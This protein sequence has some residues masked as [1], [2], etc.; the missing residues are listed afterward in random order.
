MSYTTVTN[1]YYSSTTVYIPGNSY[2]VNFE[3]RGAR[4][5]D[6]KPYAGVYG[7]RGNGRIGNFT[8]K[9]NFVARSLS[10]TIGGIGANG[11]T[12][13]G[14][15][16]GG[17][18]RSGGTGGSGAYSYSYR[19]DYGS[20]CGPCSQVCCG[21]GCSNSAPCSGGYQPGNGCAEGGLRWFCPATC[22]ATV[23]TG[24]G[25]GGGGSTGISGLAIAG[26]G[27]GGG[28]GAG[29]GNAS[30]AGG[31]SGSVGANYSGSNGSNR[32]YNGGTGG[33]GGGVGYQAGAQGGGGSGYDSSQLTLNSDGTWS[34]TPYITISY[35][36]LTPQIQSFS[37]PD[38]NSGNGI[39]QYTST[40]SYTVLD[41]DYYTLTGPGLNINSSGQFG[42]T[43]G[44]A[45]VTLGQSTAGSNSP[46]SQS[47]TLTAYAGNLST[48]QTITIDA[49]NDN[50]P[51]TNWTT[52]FSNLNPVTQI[53]LTLGTLAGVDMPCIC[54]TSA[55]GAIMVVGSSTGSPILA[56]NGETVKLRITT[57]PYNTDISGV[58]GVYGKT[59]TLVVPVTIGSNTFNVNVITKAPV[60]QETFDFG[61]V[62]NQYPYEDIDLVEATVNPYIQTGQILVD[63]VDIPVEVKSDDPSTQV[64]INGSGWKDVR[65]I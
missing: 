51:T 25:G 59:N 12:P 10:L 62:N 1:T 13:G 22:Y 63:N 19:C 54:S 27:G 23:N 58:S 30:S 46:V 20:V 61:D 50:T 18:I 38:L 60:I 17:G 4:G 57:L 11:S 39:P 28:G 52:T 32:G 37:A 2:N 65:S 45:N 49:R 33:G 35:Y 8:F 6:G 26:G 47:Y 31:W 41:C 5:G 15:G 55:S 44:N 48:S 64:N 36:A 9:S 16:G 3:I 53:D 14:G 56:S 42:A 24:G 29:G 43:S 34:S 40:I 21:Y 7:A